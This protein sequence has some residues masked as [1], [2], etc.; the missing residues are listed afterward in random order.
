MTFRNPNQMYP[1]ELYPLREPLPEIPKNHAGFIALV[2]FITL[3]LVAGG[4]IFGF[5]RAAS[6][7]VP[8]LEAPAA[9]LPTQSP[10]P[11]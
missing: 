8:R 5:W 10:T 9:P 7:P 2:L 3:L 4:M 1:G 6:A 11:K